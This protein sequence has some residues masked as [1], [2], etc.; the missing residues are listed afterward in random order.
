MALLLVE[1]DSRLP[2]IVGTLA[3]SSTQDGNMAMPSA[4]Q[5]PAIGSSSADH[6]SVP[7]NFWVAVLMGLLF[8][9]ASRW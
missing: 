7:R 6:L 9:Y 1:G 5:P 2:G 4:S 3:N 8:A